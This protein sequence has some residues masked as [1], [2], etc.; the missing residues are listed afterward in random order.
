MANRLT[1]QLDTNSTAILAAGN[2]AVPVAD[3]DAPTQPGQPK[4][5][6]LNDQG[7]KLWIVDGLLDDGSDRANVVGIRIAS[8]TAPEVKRFTP[9]AFSSLTLTAYVN[10]KTG[11]LT[12]MYEGELAAASGSGRRSGGESQAA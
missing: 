7:V 3:W 2:A 11:Q 12:A 9:I 10:R 5:Q 8:A 6:A 4:P 1:H